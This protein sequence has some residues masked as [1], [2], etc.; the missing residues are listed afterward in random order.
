MSCH[1]SS[2]FASE[3][4]DSKALLNIF[5]KFNQGTELTEGKLNILNQ[6]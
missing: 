6:V 4:P 1:S 3:G 2:A 5:L